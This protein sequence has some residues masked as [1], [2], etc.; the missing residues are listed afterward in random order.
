MLSPVRILPGHPVFAE[1]LSLSKVILDPAIFLDFTLVDL[2][3]IPAVTV[4]VI[5]LRDDS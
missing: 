3:R 5:P 1:L 4:E 2:L